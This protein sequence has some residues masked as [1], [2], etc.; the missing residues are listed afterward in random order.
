VVRE[1]RDGDVEAEAIAIRAALRVAGAIAFAD[2]GR[3]PHAHAQRV[4]SSS[5]VIA[6][7]APG[8]TAPLG[9]TTV[10]T[11]RP[12]CASL[13]RGSPGALAEAAVTALSEPRESKDGC[14]Y[15]GGSSA[16]TSS[17]AKMGRR[18][19]A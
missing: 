17:A 7:V 18:I 5:P 9:S 12:A 8:I 1:V 10:T 13:R 11:S 4:T 3:G 15:A 2:L 14:A 6:T 19:A 16:S